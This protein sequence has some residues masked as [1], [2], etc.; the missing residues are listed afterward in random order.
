[1]IVTLT[2][3]FIHRMN[4]P[5]VNLDILVS[6]VERQTAIALNSR[7]ENFSGSHH[8]PEKLIVIQRQDHDNY[9]HLKD[10]CQSVGLAG[11]KEW[12]DVVIPERCQ[13]YLWK[14][15]A[16]SNSSSPVLNPI[17]QQSRC[18]DIKDIRARDNNIKD[19]QTEDIWQAPGLRTWAT[20]TV[21]STVII[22]G[23]S[24]TIRCLETFSYEISLQLVEM[25]PTLWMLSEPSSREFFATCDETE[26]L[27]QLAI[28]ALHKIT[29]FEASFFIEMLCLFKKCKSIQDW[30]RILKTIVQILPKA[31]VIIDLNVLGA[32]NR[33]AENWPDD[34]QTMISQLISGFSSKLS[35]MLLSSRLLSS[36]NR[37]TLVVSVTSKSRQLLQLPSRKRPPEMS[38][39][40]IRCLSTLISTDLIVDSQT[41]YSSKA[42]LGAKRTCHTHVS[43]T[44]HR[45][46]SVS[47]LDNLEKSV[48]GR[49]R[50]NERSKEP[51]GNM[52]GVSNQYSLPH[53]NDIAVAII[54]AL[55]LEADPVLA[56]FDHHWDIQSFGNLQMDKNAYSLG[57]IGNHNVVLV[58]MPGMGRAAAATVAASCRRS[59]PNIRLA[60]LVGIC[61]AVPFH[62]RSIEILLGDVIISDGLVVYDFGR[63]FPDKFV[64]K[65]GAYDSARG[66]KNLTIQDE[67]PNAP[68]Q[69]PSQ[70]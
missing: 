53:R 45:N 33:H 30:L 42:V 63:Q 15:L 29:H 1:M 3:L 28:Q 46:N 67:S 61:G 23:D 35:I 17:Y 11:E 19:I 36:R 62:N 41:G 43:G 4:M 69:T 56:V 70:H 38:S 40:S 10:W 52:C 13:S 9:L 57:R 54:C 55:P 12:Q 25:Y 48:N 37:N 44:P 68:K 8:S 64:R 39:A 18:R 47:D 22:Q 59:F 6:E 27:R 60:L 66:D 5:L 31:Y 20:S 26:L 51:S 32:R 16:F 2:H 50:D 7:Q 21:S 14:L 58:H 65:D 34:F 24:Q 49:R